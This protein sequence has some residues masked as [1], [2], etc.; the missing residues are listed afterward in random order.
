MTCTA[1]VVRP[2]TAVSSPDDLA[3][4]YARYAGMVAGLTGRLVGVLDDAASDLADDLAQEVWLWVAEG[5]VDPATAR[6]ADLSRLVR[7]VV[8]HHD[9]DTCTRAIPS[10]LLATANATSC[11]NCGRAIVGSGHV[12]RSN[13][14]ARIPT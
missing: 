6:A 11:P 4:L 5:A 10:G 7:F 2:T 3:A 8:A 9:R 13:N 14:T 12:C 1:V